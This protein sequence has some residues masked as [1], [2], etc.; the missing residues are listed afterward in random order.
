M[1]MG[2]SIPAHQR[3]LTNKK[4][5]TIIRFIDNIYLHKITLRHNDDGTFTYKCDV[6][7]YTP[8]DYKEIVSNYTYASSIIEWKRLAQRA[9]EI[10]LTVL[11][12]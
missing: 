9:L 10:N 6:S 8:Q 3:Y 2:I 12:Q 7:K 1:G 11:N 4:R 5:S